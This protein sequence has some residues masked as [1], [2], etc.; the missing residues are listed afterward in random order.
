MLKRILNASIWLLLLSGLIVTLGFVNKEQEAEPCKGIE[1]AIAH[2]T[3]NNFI[4]EQDIKTIVYDKGDALIGHPMATL[5]IAQMEKIIR[6]NPYVD[7]AEVY[8]SID[9]KIKIDVTQRKPLL[10]I[11]NSHF[12]S[13]YIDEKGTFMPTS[14]K[15]TANVMIATGAIKE[16]FRIHTL[17]LGANH[18]QDSTYKKTIVDD[19]FQLASYIN[20]NELLKSLIVQVYIN[21]D[22]TIELTPRVGNAQI[23]LGTIDNLEEK[24]NKLLLVY[25]KGFSKTGWDLYETIDLNYKNQV[26]CTKKNSTTQTQ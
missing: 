2:E 20:K 12:E 25:E 4:D 9:G 16:P 7:N 11:F 10:R 14:E 5:N 23:L 21:E 1:I 6:N 22:G 15:Y 18:S 13:Y 19:L 26:V 8:E 3:E 24:L 17:N